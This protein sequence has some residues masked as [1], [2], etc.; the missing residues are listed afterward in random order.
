MLLFLAAISSAIA[1]P[2]L[3]TTLF[4]ASP[5]GSVAIGAPF[6]IAKFEVADQDDPVRL[7]SLA[8]LISETG[9]ADPW[10][11]AANVGAD[12]GAIQLFDDDTGLQIGPTVTPAN[13]GGAIFSAT[14]FACS[15][16]PLSFV[17][18]QDSVRVLTIRLQLQFGTDLTTIRGSLIP[19]LAA[20][21]VQTDDGED[22]LRVPTA[23]VDG[24]V[25]QVSPAEAEVPELTTMVFCG[26][27]LAF[28]G[29]SR[30][31]RRH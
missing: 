28:I 4:A 22:V 31:R 19:S 9:S 5:V 24:N 6:P 11:T 3:T 20:N 27:G 2:I 12:I 1:D 29:L 8:F 21:A 30:L 26:I 23:R 18:P 16:A 17:F 10:T 13:C 25:L 15:F 14:S 7:N